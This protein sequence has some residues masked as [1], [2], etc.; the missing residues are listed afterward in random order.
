MGQA[1]RNAETRCL[2]PQGRLQ[3]APPNA[4]S[5][6]GSSWPAGS[7]HPRRHSADPMRLHPPAR[8]HVT[9]STKCLHPTG[10]MHAK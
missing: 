4:C 9:T 8:P 2:V 7:P 6:A 5:G 3:R 10:R 1:A